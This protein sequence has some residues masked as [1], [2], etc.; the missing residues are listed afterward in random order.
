MGSRKDIKKLNLQ[1]AN[2]T[3]T[4]KRI[5]TTIRKIRSPKRSPSDTILCLEIDSAPI[6]QEDRVP[7]S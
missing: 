6:T 2:L 5:F 3:V 7:V 4:G 1:Q